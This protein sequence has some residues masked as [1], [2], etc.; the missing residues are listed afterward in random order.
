MAGSLF[1]PPTVSRQLQIWET[2]ASCHFLLSKWGSFHICL[3]YNKM[4]WRI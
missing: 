3:D 2:G 4:Y 1:E